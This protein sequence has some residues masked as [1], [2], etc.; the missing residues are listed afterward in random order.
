MMTDAAVT[1]FARVWREMRPACIRCGMPFTA[2]EPGAM[3]D[4]S[5]PPFSPRYCPPCVQVRR[6][7]RAKADIVQ[8]PIVEVRA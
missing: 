5:G 1:M 4:R 2:R 8:G 7:E 3:V 6:A